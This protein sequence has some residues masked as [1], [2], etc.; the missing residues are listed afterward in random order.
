MLPS[1]SIFGVTLVPAVSVVCPETDNGEPSPCLGRG[2]LRAG[3]LGIAVLRLL[4][5]PPET[6]SKFSFYL[7]LVSALAV[8]EKNGAA[9]NGRNRAVAEVSHPRDGTWP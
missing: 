9:E 1:F 3:T 4:M 7:S 2:F 8:H 6:T 5:M